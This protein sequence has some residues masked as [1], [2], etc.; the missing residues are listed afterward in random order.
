MDIIRQ[1]E[2]EQKKDSLTEFSVGD[3]VKIDYRIK[4]GSRERI[5]AFEGTVIKI[6]G[7]GVRRAF[8]VRRLSYGVGVERTFLLHSPRVENI[9]VIR[10][11]K[12]RRAKLFYLRDRV[13][14]AAKLKEK[15]DY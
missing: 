5:Q 12:A 4:E 7:E 1:I 6:Q 9:K 2:E 13:G 14:K 15:T 11:G 10:R 8:T 3:Q